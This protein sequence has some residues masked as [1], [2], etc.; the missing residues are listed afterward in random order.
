ME[1]DKKNISSDNGK[2][3]KK[4]TLNL[5]GYGEQKQKRYLMNL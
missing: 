1:I 4:E 3:S 5:I 2:I